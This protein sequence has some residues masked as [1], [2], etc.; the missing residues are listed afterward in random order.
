MAITSIKRDWG[1]NP[2]IVRITSTD[3]LAAVGTVGYLTAQLDNVV[4]LNAG[5]FDWVDSDMALVV[6]SNG[7]GFFTVASGFA[8]L[9]PFAIITGVTTPTIVG[10][11]A[12][13]DSTGGNIGEDAAT[14]INGGNLQAGLSGTAGTVASFPSA[15]TSGSLVLAAVTNSSGNFST[16]ISNAAAVG[17]SQVVSIPDSG[18]STANFLL[19]KSAGTQHVTVGSLQVDAGNV[20]AGLA[21]GGTAGK[22]I[23]YSATTTVGSLQLAAIANAGNFN[24]IVS[25]ASH[26]Q[27]ST[28]SIPDGGQ[29]TSVFLISNSAGTQTVAT[30]NLAMTAG[31]VQESV[32]NALTA[33]A[34][35]GQG[36]ALAL[37]RQINR[38]TTV[39]SSG[40]S[41]ALPAAVAGRVVTVINAAAAN[42]MDVFPASGEVINALAANTALSVAADKVVT[43]YC[44]VAGTWNSLLTA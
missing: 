43:F 9:T 22:F 21:T 3:T 28:V 20:S 17:Q 5:A 7:W 12:V 40:D 10:H 4:A 23:S 35:G 13:Y 11:I 32:A 37:T 18:A 34:G 19:S 38:V 25:N 8:S 29:A 2:S 1:V 33:H 44:A 26:G 16:T 31:Y 42:A 41:V 39:G 24:V 27:S 15:A 6:A 14:A 36:S 30:G